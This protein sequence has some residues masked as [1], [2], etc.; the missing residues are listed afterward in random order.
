MI[1]K[2]FLSKIKIF[3]N[4]KYYFIYNFFFNILYIAIL[5]KKAH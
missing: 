4:Y 1:L 2:I 5:P 3:N